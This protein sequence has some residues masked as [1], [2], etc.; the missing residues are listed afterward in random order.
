MGTRLFLRLRRTM[1][2]V[3]WMAAAILGMAGV[4]AHAGEVSVAVAANFLKPMQS[5]APDFTAATGHQV[6]VSG[7]STGKL[8]SQIVA[9]APFDVLLA[10]DAKT[11]KRLVDEGHGVA[12]SQF[13]YAIGQLVLWSADAELV[14]GDGAILATDRYTKIAVANPKLAPYGAA[15]Y[16]VLEARKLLDAVTPRMVTGENIGQTYQFV[17][18]RNAEIGFV[19]LSQVMVP[20]QPVAGSMWRIPQ[21]LYGEIRQ[22]A[23]LLERGESNEAARALMDYLRTPA[24]REKI[25]SYG[26]AD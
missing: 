15:A 14:D 1:R 3:V 4:G 13:T 23:V 10:A 16:E 6:V 11:P 12:G 17:L 5:I 24:A 18:T 21:D 19:A 20:G 8:Y 26:Y 9:G 2:R 25:R 22:D 7:G